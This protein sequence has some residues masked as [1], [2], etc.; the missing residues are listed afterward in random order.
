MIVLRTFRPMDSC[1]EEPTK[2]SIQAYTAITPS[3]KWI[4]SFIGANLKL[5]LYRRFVRYR[6]TPS[7]L[8]PYLDTW[9]P[10]FKNWGESAREIDRPWP[11]APPA[12]YFA[13]TRYDDNASGQDVIHP[14]GRQFRGKLFLLI[15]AG[16]S[17]ATFQ[18][19]QIAQ[20][21]GLGTLVGQP[22]GAIYEASTGEHF[23]SGRDVGMATVHS[24]LGKS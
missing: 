10:S 23:I 9:D 17:S 21:N 8:A 4:R 18:F 14:A 16:N 7:D 15:D 22:T 6:Q 3:R 13:L 1:C 24:L 5:G 11:T 19:A 20:R 2:S 12:H